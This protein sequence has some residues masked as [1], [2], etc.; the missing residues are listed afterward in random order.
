MSPTRLNP[1]MKIPPQIRTHEREATIR[2]TQI[3]VWVVVDYI[4]DGSKPSEIKKWHPQLTD[5]DIKAVKVYYKY[6]KGE[7]DH[8]IHGGT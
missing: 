2:N 5:D 6:H 3:P 7:I 4:N 8:Y 1:D